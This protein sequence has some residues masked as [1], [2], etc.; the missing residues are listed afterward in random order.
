M[1][2]R[3]NRRYYLKINPWVEGV[4]GDGIGEVQTVNVPFGSDTF[5][6]LNG[7]IDSGRPDLYLKNSRIKDL[8]VRNGAFQKTI[9]LKDSPEPQIIQFACLLEGEVSFEIKS[10]YKGTKYEDTAMSGILYLRIPPER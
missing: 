4:S 6:F 5:L 9:T 3:E 8:I 10:V 2:K 1:R 7:F